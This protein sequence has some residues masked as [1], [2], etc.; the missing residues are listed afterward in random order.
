[1]ICVN[2]KTPATAFLIKVGAVE[3]AKSDDSSKN[4]AWSRGDRVLAP[5]GGNHYSGTVA[6]V[7]RRPDGSAALHVDFDDG[8]K[9]VVPE[10]IAHRLREEAEASSR[11]RAIR[12]IKEE[13]IERGKKQLIPKL[14]PNYG[15]PL[16]QSLQSPIL[17]TLGGGLVG[18]I[19]GALAGAAL[20]GKFGVGGL[21]A[22]VGGL[23][24]GALG[25]LLAYLTKNQSNEN[26][27]NIIRTSPGTATYGDYLADRRVI[28][29]TL[30]YLPYR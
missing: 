16:E 13:G 25:A 12:D 26:K 7:T 11:S 17:P 18:A 21:G 5:W 4:L 2:G 1:M 28:G 24:A 22:T 9:A 14:F 20:G 23:S 30:Q 15:T 29:D 10:D 8:D 27:A 19:P 3:P 6:K